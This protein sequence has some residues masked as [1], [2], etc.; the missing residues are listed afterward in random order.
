MRKKTSVLALSALQKHNQLLH[1][2]VKTQEVPI[3]KTYLQNPA[4]NVISVFIYEIPKSTYIGFK[5]GLLGERL[6][7][8]RSLKR[9]KVF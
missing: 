3:R 6:I 5:I 9:V 1:I 7:F 2:I 8:T 4:S